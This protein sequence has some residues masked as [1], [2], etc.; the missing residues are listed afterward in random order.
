[1][2]P[3]I[4]IENKYKLQLLKKLH[5]SFMILPY[6]YLGETPNRSGSQAAKLYGLGRLHKD[7]ES[8]GFFAFFSKFGKL[9]RLVSIRQ[10]MRRTK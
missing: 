5:I 9:W 2:L 4:L 1:M 3:V 8:K 6:H 7:L 10:W